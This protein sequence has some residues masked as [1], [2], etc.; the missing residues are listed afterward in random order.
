MRQGF[1]VGLLALLLTGIVVS[2]THSISAQ[3]S[4]SNYQI[5]SDSVNTGGLLA[6]SSQYQL[7]STVGEQATGPQSS[8]NY[9]IRSGY[10]QMQE[11]YI[12]MTAPEDIVMD[13]AIGG[14]TGGT[15]NGST[16][17]TV[18]TDNVAG[19]ELTVTA[20]NEPAMTSGGD[21]IADY[22]PAG[23]TADYTFSIATNE[24][25][26]AFT[27]DGSHVADRFLSSGGVC[28]SGTDVS[29]R[30]WDGF[31]TSS[32]VIATS[33]NSNHPAGT[34]TRVGVRVGVGSAVNQAPGNYVAT[35]TITALPL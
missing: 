14:V 28:G 7:E 1:H 21:S 35:T 13:T 22:V 15:S 8:S 16:S 19:Y 23:G 9:E 32:D 33:P 30:C 17:V 3:M 27:V 2:G 29:D 6:S 10:Q 20:A 34:L 4:S 26:F 24:S 25:A 5:Q 12:A 11:V 31:S 18:T